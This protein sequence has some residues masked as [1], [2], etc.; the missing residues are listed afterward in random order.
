MQFTVKYIA[1]QQ[2]GA[3]GL[4]F[5]KP[6]IFSAFGFVALLEIYRCDC[7]LRAKNIMMVHAK[8]L[9]FFRQAFFRPIESHLSQG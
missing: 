9:F 2:Q 7:V 4:F 8:Q 1:A 5:C 6:D 3:L